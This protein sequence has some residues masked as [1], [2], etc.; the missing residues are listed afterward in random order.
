MNQ[1]TITTTEF[2]IMESCNFGIAQEDFFHVDRI[3]AFHV[4]ILVTKGVIYVTETAEDGSG[5]KDYEIHEGDF[6]FLKSGYRHFGKKAIQKGTQWYYIHFRTNDNTQL[7]PADF[8]NIPLP[9]SELLRYSL[10]LPKL[11]SGTLGSSIEKKLHELVAYFHSTLPD[12]KLRL[13]AMLYD[14]LLETDKYVRTSQNHNTLSDKIA[15]Y[16]EEHTAK[17]FSAAKL[18]KHF[19]LS[20]K[21]MAAVFKREKQTTMQQYHTVLRMR[22]ACTLLQTTTLSVGEISSR[23]GYQDMLYFSKC[24]HAHTGISPTGYRKQL[25]MLY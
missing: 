8:D 24:F 9:S 7:P 10:L 2:P 3:A 6:L 19:F 13:N 22:K 5:E 4:C 14:F 12:R 20:Y 21:H 18:E 11:L 25:P 23:L 16:L 15:L 17:P 1:I